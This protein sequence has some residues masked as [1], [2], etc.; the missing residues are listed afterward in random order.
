MAELYLAVA[1]GPGGFK[2]FVALKQIKP[3]AKNDERFVTL[4]LEEARISAALSHPGI[5][6][7]FDLGEDQGEFFIAMEF[8][9][10]QN[11]DEIRRAASIRKTHVP[12]GF[13]CTAVR[14]AC[15][16]LH[17][18]HHYSDPAGRPQPVVH[19]D[20]TPTNIMVTY[21]GNVKVVD[22]GLAKSLGGW[23]PGARPKTVRGTLGFMSPEQ[24]RAE[25]P[26]ARS[27]LYSAGVV[28]YE[29]ITGQEFLHDED[30]ERRVDRILD[31]PV[32]RADALN[33]KV[34]SALADV[35]QRAISRVPD[36]RFPTGKD[37]ALAIEDAAHDLFDMDQMSSVLRSLFRR[38]M[39]VT[40]ALLARIETG[41]RAAQLGQ[42]ATALIQSGPLAEVASSDILSIESTPPAD[43][44]GND[45]PRIHGRGEQVLA[46]DDDPAVCDLVKICLEKQ[47]YRAVGVTDPRAAVEAV[48]KVGPELVI[49]DVM[50]PGLNGFDLCRQIREREHSRHIPIVFLSGACSLEERVKALEVGGDDFIRKPFSPVELAARVRTHIDRVQAIHRAASRKPPSQTSFLDR[51]ARWLSPRP[52]R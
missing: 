17:Y 28:L 32:P 30:E 37:M 25:P 45:G 51:L 34:P 26:E 43:L 6:Q 38:R 2:K 12:L 52:D 50:M 20:V 48:E 23:K 47:G 41:E 13:S 31:G 46:V 1:T 35:V 44:G 7:V 15:L 49:L 11:L 16:A 5:G 3:E 10:G 33:P 36:E 29:M 39:D 4:F 18:A 14:D 21:E 27:D 24:L 8:I 9:E 42:D 22:F 19:R 40:R